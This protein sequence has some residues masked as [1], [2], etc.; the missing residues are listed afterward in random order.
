[1]DIEYRPNE[2]DCQAWAGSGRERY[3]VAE[4]LDR[5]DTLEAQPLLWDEVTGAIRFPEAAHVTARTLDLALAAA[6]IFCNAVEMFHV[7]DQLSPEAYPVRKEAWRSSVP[8]SPATPSGS[9]TAPF[10]PRPGPS[11]P[12]PYILVVF[13]AF[14]SS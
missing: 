1:M 11:H 14:G 5:K 2:R 9:A 3:V 12:S 6:V 10:T 4:A 7:L 8:T 13:I